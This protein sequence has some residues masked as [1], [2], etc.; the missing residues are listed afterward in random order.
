MIDL[1]NIIDSAVARHDAPYLVAMLTNRDGVVWSG[2]SGEGRPG[3]PVDTDTPLRLW[4]M[5][6]AVGSVAILLLVDRGQLSLD[7]P[8]DDV[9]P[10]L[11]DV[12]VVQRVEESGP[13]MRPA[14]TRITLRHLLTHSSGLAYPLYSSTMM[15]YAQS[16]NMPLVSE[17]TID[18]LR[19]PLVFEP[20]TDFAYS[21][22]LDWAGLAVERISGASIDKFCHDEVFEPLTLSGM[23]FQKAD[24]EAALPPAFARDEEGNLE[25]TV[26]DPPTEPQLY[27]LGNGLFS[28]TTDYARFLRFILRGGELDG[29]RIMSP[30][31][32]D[33]LTRDLMPE[34][35]AGPLRSEI[36]GFSLDVDLYGR[37]SAMGHTAGFVRC[38][39]GVE[40][41]RSEGSLWWAGFLNTHYW[42]D[43]AMDIAGLLMTQTLPFCDPRL[44]QVFEQFE[45]AAYRSLSTS[46][47][48]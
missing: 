24:V 38:R 42:I 37:G 5:T 12:Q 33:L 11:R 17:G 46:T 41:R 18:D 16:T 30:Q 10:E 32:F 36:P 47:S 2:A 48:A 9:L 25:P 34:L 39:E 7:A 29:T 3:V 35:V 6:K 4:S 20:G 13:V 14:N 1:Q 27:G 31:T 45:G 43:P 22:G 40:G 26:F 44:M 23:T 19:Y 15:A 21:I 8:I 28:R